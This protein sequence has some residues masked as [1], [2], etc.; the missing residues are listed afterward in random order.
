MAFIRRRYDGDFGNM[1]RADGDSYKGDLTS[2][3]TLADYKSR[4]LAWTGNPYTV[5]NDLS[6]L[7]WT[8]NQ[9]VNQYPLILTNRMN[10]RQ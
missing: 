2:V 7:C 4:Y 8:L 10:V 3:P 1:Y 9:P 5:W 6:N